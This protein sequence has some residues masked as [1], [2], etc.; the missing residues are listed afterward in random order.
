MEVASRD[1]GYQELNLDKDIIYSLDQPLEDQPIIMLQTVINKDEE[2]LRR[3]KLNISAISVKDENRLLL[4]QGN[5]IF[6]LFIKC[7]I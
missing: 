7:F 3:D 1:Y 6:F 2:Q 4:D 5:H